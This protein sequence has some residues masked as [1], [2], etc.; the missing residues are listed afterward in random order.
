MTSERAAE[1]FCLWGD[2]DYVR[3]RVA[4]MRAA[5]CDIPAVIL[6]NPGNYDRDLDDLGLAL[7]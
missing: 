3:E 2:R 7:A 5:G 6:G 4:G 1:Y